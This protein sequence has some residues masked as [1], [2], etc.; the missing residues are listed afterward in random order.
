M[1]KNLLGLDHA[2]LRV[3]DLDRAAADFARMGFTL[4]PRGRHS[5]GTENHCLMFGFDYLELLWVP[6][7]V[8][9]PFYADFPLAGEGMTGLALKSD[10][11]AG[12]RTA[13][14]KAGLHPEPLL[15][16]SRPVAAEQGIRRDARFR[17]VAL[18]AERTLGGRSFACQHFTP[19]LVWRPGSR[20]HAN[21]VT[22]INKVVI[23]TADPAAVGLLWGRVFDVP[24]HPIPGGIAINT[25]AAPIVA[26]TPA[27]LAKQLPGVSRPR[28]SGQAVF[29]AVYLS[30]GDLALAAA[31]L[32]AGGVHPV[33]LPDGSLAIGPDEA[34][35]ITLVLK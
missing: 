27:A 11:A 14:D 6:P 28:A 19:E 32:R 29:A 18:P 15:E 22:G 23:A 35:G 24:R 4:A 33:S 13:W 8:A 7:G 31:A 16:F 5:L 2:V 34:H 12:L 17:V 30:T 20:R 25:G 1:R 26:L 9:A 21:Q 3:D 10:D